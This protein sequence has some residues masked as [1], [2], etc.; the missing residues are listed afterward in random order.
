MN[1]PTWLQRQRGDATRAAQLRICP[2]CHMAIITGLD[3]DVAALLVRVDPTPVD[4]IGEAKALLSGRTTYDLVGGNKRKEIYP[5]E[6][7]HIAKSRKYPV[8]P[9]HRCGE[10]LS[11]HVAETTERA[12]RQ[13]FPHCPPF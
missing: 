8:L 5:R 4:E 3:A 13:T 10:S 1:A 7:D 12:T 11:A 6:R 9:Q 2:R